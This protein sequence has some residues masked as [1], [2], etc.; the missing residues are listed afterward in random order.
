MTLTIRFRCPPEWFDHLPPPVQAREG[1]PEWLRTMPAEAF[2][3]L[4]QLDVR[5]VKQCPPFL[6][7]MGT[8]WLMRLAAD[9]QVED[10]EFSWDWTIPSTGIE[11][12]PRSPLGFHTSAQAT[13]SPFSIDGQAIV[14]FN[15]HW[16][17]ETP[18]NYSCLFTHPVNRPDLPFQTLTGLV[19]HDH[20]SSGLTHFPALWTDPEFSGTLP[21]GTPVA[22]LFLI[23]RQIITVVEPMDP[24]AIEKIEET[25]GRVGSDTG[26]YRKHFR[27]RTR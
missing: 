12:F 8:G 1:L 7:A 4:L 18:K 24:S 10:G 21:A 16:T 26:A 20:Y 9:V 13:G 5:T 11:Q 25:L 22:Q 15:N 23:P 2:S 6:D 17:I 14:K 27:S 19:D 3:E